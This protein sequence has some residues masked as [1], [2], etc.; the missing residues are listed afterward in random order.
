MRLLQVVIVLCL[1]G[2]LAGACVGA[3]QAEGTLYMVGHSHIDLA[4][5]WQWPE[6][7]IVARDTFS[8]ALQLMRDFPDFR[9]TQSQ[10][11]LYE[12]VAQHYPDLF[13][14][15]KQAVAD[16]KWD[17]VGGMWVE[18]DANMPSG[19]SLV[20]QCLYGQ[21]Y[22]RATFGAEA[23]L[24][25][26]PDTFGLPW[27][28]PQILKKS[29]MPEIFFA[30]FPCGPGPLYNWESPDGSQV[31]MFDAR[32]EEA[33]FAA[34]GGN[35]NDLA[36]VPKAL[37][38]VVNMMPGKAAMI[39]FGVGDHGGGPTRRDLMMFKALAQM[40][41]M[42]KVK[43]AT[44]DEAMAGMLASAGALP[45][46][47]D[48][49]EYWHRGCYTSQAKMKRHN[50][51]CETLLP[52]AEKFAVLANMTGGFEFPREL[53]ASAWRGALFNQFHD[54]L[55]G[56]SITAVYADATELYRTVEATAQAALDKAL[57]TIADRA[58][59]AGAGDAVIV[60]NPLSWPRTDIAEVTL[61]CDKVPANLTVRDA[62]G[63]SWAAQVVEHHQ[64]Y[65]SFERC[66]VIFAARDV[67]ALGFKVFWV[68]RAAA[69]PA[70]RLSAGDYWIE[71]PR[72]RVEVD[73]K[74][75]QVTAVRDKRLERQV[76][77]TGA[78]GNVLR[79]MG[80]DANA[81]EI[82]YTG[83]DTE[84]DQPTSVSVVERGPVRATIAINYFHD[85]SI[86]QQRIS[87]YDDLDRIDFP[88]TVDWRAYHTLLRVSFPVDV[89]ANAFTREIQFGNI[90]HACNGDEVPAQK[91]IDLSDGQWGV[92]L[93]NDCKYGH[94]VK[95]N[96]MT[97]TLLRS[98][99]D[100]DPVA[101]LGRH[102][103][104]YSLCPHAGGWR[105]GG[106]QRR[107][108]ELNAPLLAQAAKGHDGALGSQYSLLEATPA[109]VFVAAV[110]PC[111]DSADLLIR[112]WEAH[113]QA[114]QASV[115]LPRPP[116]AVSEVDLLEREVG[117]ASAQDDR[118][119]VSIKPYEIRSFKVAF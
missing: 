28:L 114:V 63:A 97:I 66:K 73:G 13:A 96:D 16:G 68:E 103:M 18:T 115:R 77:A 60:F 47:R 95:G 22:F 24:G 46:W 25:W 31:V 3:E 69:A 100:P 81:W 14:G 108:E 57:T 15:I 33:A 2:A 116:R 107:A 38:A 83:I 8:Q 17:I 113:G 51:Q 50:R 76:L 88:T 30:K 49:V 84:L 12:A 42:P 29:N 106:I 32:G 20:R 101:D 112:I 79:L 80:D 74:T 92:S 58:K 1:L 11:A 39:P 99:T 109:N 23:R 26:L 105:D 102:V 45:V 27:T 4:W 71:S 65:E 111:E 7:I 85:G 98:P 5:R 89:T 72:F 70:T 94:S 90:A 53:L 52:N 37:A 54:I 9:F 43:L 36:S 34:A 59:T 19:E 119:V 93:L 110:K 41:G 55:P 104:T 10:A 40:P 82:H 56:S 87:I 62:S 75:G 78:K 48:E 35:L 118:L 117:S 21:R 44:G 61:D 6:T 86:V 91:W 64:V 67:P